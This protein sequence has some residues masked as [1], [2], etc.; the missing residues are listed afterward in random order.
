MTIARALATVLA[1]T[2]ILAGTLHAQSTFKSTMPD[3]R[4][5]YGEKPAPGAAK[6]ETL[7]PPPRESGVRPLPPGAGAPPAAER[8]AEDP[9]L[10]RSQAQAELAVA[11][12]ALR[13][14]QEALDKGKEPLPGE[15]SGTAD[16]GRSRL[17]DAYWER[18]RQLE[19]RLETA[20]R[21]VERLRAELGR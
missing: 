7:R 17:N 21:D 9:E 8:P 16:K 15:R 18:Q 13:D 1:C 3:G 19:Q 6:V 20:R 12:Q 14:A 4:V 2:G 5:I 10:R 11:E